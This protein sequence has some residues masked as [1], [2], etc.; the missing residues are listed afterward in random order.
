MNARYARL[1]VLAVILVM[2]V[3]LIPPVFAPYRPHNY[4]MA[5][6]MNLANAYPNQMT[7]ETIGRTVQGRDILMF[8]IGNPAGGKILIDGV[9]HGHEG[10][11]GELL[12]QYATWLLTS[13]D[14]LADYIV[15]ETYTLLIPVVNVDEFNDDRKNAHGVDLNRNFAAGWDQAGS[16]NPSSEYYRGPGPL[17]EPESQVL[18]A[19]FQR[20]RPSFYINLHRGGE[21]LYGSSFGSYA[22]YTNLHSKM[23]QLANQRQVA[24]YDFQSIYGGGMAMSDAAN[25]GITSF[26]LELIDWQVVTLDEIRTRI[27]P[28]FIPIVAVLSQESIPSYPPWDTNQDGQVDI[29]DIVL[30]ATAYGSTPGEP[31]WD[32]RADVDAD[33]QVTLFDG[34][35]V[36][37]YYKQVYTNSYTLDLSFDDNNPMAVTDYSGYDNHG[38][39]TGATWTSQGQVNGAYQFDGNDVITIPDDPSLV[40]S[41]TWTTLSVDF[42][43]KPTALL[44]GTRIVAK[45]ATSASTGSYMVGFQTSTNDP[46]NT[47]FF[48]V[49]INEN[50][51]EVV[52]NGQA[53]TVGAW[54]HVTCTY[55][56]GPG[57]TIY[58]NGA[59]AANRPL[60]GV[61]DRGLGEE[62]LFLG[63]DGGGDDRRYLVGVLDE[64]KISPAAIHP[65]GQ[66]PPPPEPSPPPPEPS[67]PTYTEFFGFSSYP[68]TQSG[69]YSYSVI[70]DIIQEMDA[71]NLNIYRMGFAPSVNP[72]PYVQY[73]LDNCDYDLI[74]DIWHI[75]PPGTMSDSQWRDLEADVLAFCRDFA[76]YQDR[77]WIEPVNEREDRDLA[78]HIQPIVSAIRNAGYTYTIV[79]NKFGQSWRD[80]ASIDDPLDKFWTGYHYYFDY[81]RVAD[82]KADMT[83]AL[84]LGLKLINTEVG[85][86][87]DEYREFSQYEVDELNEFLVWCAQRDIWNAVWMRYG[88]GNL[89]TYKN[90]GLVNPLT[91][92]HLR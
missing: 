76:A 66:L 52:L 19:I 15:A 88:L 40:G 29:Q 71:N 3:S 13:G 69:S 81:W 34:I 54:H 5:D 83:T 64:V 20:W 84:N 41:D 8:K 89:Q 68:R 11:G 92:T 49:T 16:S 47:L 27:L 87:A 43:V 6:F 25:I 59:E 62:P 23:V 14:P 35:I 7:Y 63:Y 9:M 45:K 55:E 56:S 51:E 33:G 86:D 53:L 78:D 4:L 30:V 24:A 42:W 90:Y 75:Y 28:K 77:I 70:D 82:A 18:V 44:R 57:L 73:Y 32:P 74:V 50:W 21:I 38:I 12:L 67:P 80:M 36:L 31:L 22:Y 26:L 85:A 65:E 10:M 17:S 72:N 91:E 61:I 48:G 79:A 37:Q 1:T 2:T 39:V 58:V 60:T 46:P